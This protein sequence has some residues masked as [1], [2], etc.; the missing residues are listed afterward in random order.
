MANI[1]TVLSELT[2]Q[3]TLFRDLLR[4]NDPQEALRC[5]YSVKAVSRWLD[6]ALNDAFL[7][8][9]LASCDKLLAACNDKFQQS[10][11]KHLIFNN[12]WSKF[13]ALINVLTTYNGT[14]HTRALVKRHF[15]F[16]VKNGAPKDFVASLLTIRIQNNRVQ[17]P[18]KS[19]VRS[20]EHAL[21][22]NNFVLALLLLP[23]LRPHFRE[24][25]PAHFQALETAFINKDQLNLESDVFYRILRN[26]KSSVILLQLLNPP[27]RRI[28]IPEGKLLTSNDLA[29]EFK[30]QYTSMF[31][32]TSIPS[33]NI[34]K[35]YSRGT[36]WLVG[37]AF[38]GCYNISYY[39]SKS[40]RHEIE[41]PSRPDV[42]YTYEGLA[43]KNIYKLIVKTSLGEQ[44]LRSFPHQF[45]AVTKQSLSLPFEEQPWFFGNISEEEAKSVLCGAASNTF[46]LTLSRGL[47]I[48]M[49]WSEPKRSE[50]PS[51]TYLKIAEAEGLTKAIATVMQHCKA[52]LGFYNGGTPKNLALYKFYQIL[53]GNHGTDVLERAKNLVEE[54]NLDISAIRDPSPIWTYFDNVNVKSEVLQWLIDNN[55]Y[56]HG[57]ENPSLLA[58]A[59]AKNGIEY[60]KY[61]L[62]LGVKCDTSSLVE[63]INKIPT[64]EEFNT[65][66]KCRRTNLDYSKI[67]G[68]LFNKATIY[69][70]RWGDFGTDVRSFG[71]KQKL[72][73]LAWRFGNDD[74]LF[75]MLPREILQLIMQYDI[76]VPYWYTI[77]ELILA[78]AP[79][80]S[81]KVLVTSVGTILFIARYS[82]LLAEDTDVIALE[83]LCQQDILYRG[84]KTPA[85]LRQLRKILPNIVM[86]YRNQSNP[87]I[88]F[89]IDRPNMELLRAILE[90]KIV[91]P[92]LFSE[93]TRWDVPPSWMACHGRKRAAVELLC[94]HGVMP[95]ECVVNNKVT[96]LKSWLNFECIK[97][98]MYELVQ[99]CLSS[100]E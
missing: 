66:W 57:N 73:Y 2:I 95:L 63:L 84:P 28:I 74:N 99:K 11:I 29:G 100:T 96:Q 5:F 3:T 41:I 90:T 76:D 36:K 72:L 98:D 20:L 87:I 7:V 37:T 23:Y 44:F 17:F 1:E 53:N 31:S 47:N 54:N 94:K 88:R 43:T 12:D 25:D 67:L 33:D 38:K 62:D 27:T 32:Y 75:K 40:K 89:A 81:V 52:I 93:P 59:I 51:F 6:H 10:K 39:D 82:N 77:G 18:A 49:Y 79:K 34:A 60:G 9:L 61:L 85:V 55:V 64:R 92:K 65:F 80:R 26:R 58:K 4:G 71:E 30:F 78:S 69:E 45:V 16:A 48:Y 56:L 70:R 97:E 14:Y 50:Q 8:R 22:Y 35:F 19:I 42:G 15:L 24:V 68:K 91:D 13:E 83:Q 86:N 21:K 46:F